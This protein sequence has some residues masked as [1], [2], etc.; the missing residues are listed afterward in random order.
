MTGELSND[1]AL[2]VPERVVARDD[3][4]ILGELATSAQELRDTALKHLYG[5]TKRTTLEVRA[6]L[7]E[8]LIADP[9]T[10]FETDKIINEFGL[11]LGFDQHQIEID[12]IV[13]EHFC[14][15]GEWLDLESS[16]LSSET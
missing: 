6:M 11:W 8:K 5:S 9:A 3:P 14:Q 4:F 10:G 13:L 7:R 2:S 1:E 12:I 15:H 16:P